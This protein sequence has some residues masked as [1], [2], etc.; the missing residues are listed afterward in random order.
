MVPQHVISA[1]T[2]HAVTSTVPLD[3]VFWRF[4]CRVDMQTEEAIAHARAAECPI[5]VALTKCD[6]PGAEPSRV[7]NQLLGLGL[8]LEE[9]GGNTMVCVPATVL[10]CASACYARLSLHA[11]RQPP[12]AA[13]V[14]L[15]RRPSC[16]Q[17]S[18]Q[19]LRW[20]MKPVP[21]QLSKA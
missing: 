2:K 12:A 11:V 17:E 4:T 5:I 15:H 21:M 6:M 8:Q 18:I 20:E 16:S 3:A 14:E 9:A 19:A 13:L 1:L 10:A 7:K